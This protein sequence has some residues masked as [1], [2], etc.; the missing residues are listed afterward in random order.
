[1]KHPTEWYECL[2]C[3][4]KGQNIR[5]QPCDAKHADKH[6]AKLPFNKG[7]RVNESLEA[8]ETLL[9]ALLEE[10]LALSQM[11]EEAMAMSL[12]MSLE[13]GNDGNPPEK[14]DDPDLEK[15]LAMSFEV[16]PA[17][18]KEVDGDTQKTKKVDGDTKDK[19]AK[20]GD[21]KDKESKDGDTKDQESKDMQ[22][23]LALSI[24]SMNDPLKDMQS[25]SPRKDLPAQEELSALCSEANLYNMQCLVNMGFTKEQA[26]WGVKRANDSNGSLDVALQHA[27][28][29]CD[30]DILMAKR[31]KLEDLCKNATITTSKDVGNPEP[32]KP[33]CSI[34]S[35]VWISIW[36]NVHTM[37]DQP[38]QLIM[39]G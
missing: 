26:I 31:R 18:E 36:Q 16:L 33:A 2:K 10:E 19:E 22:R 32:P 23:A 12:S 14:T 35:L 8:E 17:R 27:S 38:H 25:D 7:E 15:A 11:V 20:D 39:N 21:T 9:K 6:C 29:R 28:W 34:L 13:P 24:H 37:F 3:H 5:D 1:M 30:A 4:Q